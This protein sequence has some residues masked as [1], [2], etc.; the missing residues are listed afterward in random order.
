MCPELFFMLY[1]ASMSRIP[2][3]FSVVSGKDKVDLSKVSKTKNT[4]K[5]TQT[6]TTLGIIIREPILKR[7]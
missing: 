2:N 7:K 3:G 1:F 5:P 4:K 6:K